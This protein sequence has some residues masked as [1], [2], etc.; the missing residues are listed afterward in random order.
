MKIKKLFPA[1]S[2]IALAASALALSVFSASDLFAVSQSGIQLTSGVWPVMVRMDY[3]PILQISIK[4]AHGA[5]LTE[6]KLDFTKTTHVSDIAEVEVFVGG[7]LKGAG[8]LFGKAKPTKNNPIVTVKGSKPTPIADGKPIWIS[9]KMRTGADI[10]GTVNCTG[11]QIVLDGR[12]FSIN[13]VPA[14]QRVGYAVA[15]SGDLGSK[16]YRIPAVTTTKKGTLVATFDIRYG[17]AGDLPAN[18][19][20]GV[21]TSVDGGKTWTPVKSVLSSKDMKVKKGVGDP[22]ILYDPKTNTVWIAALWAPQSG[23]PIWTS[24]SG[25]TATDNC[26]Q[27]LLINSK[28]EG[29]TWSKPKN[30]TADIKRL[31]DS[32][33]ARWGLIFQGPGAGICTKDGTLIFPGQV[34]MR[35]AGN[36]K[37]ESEGASQGVLIYSKDNGKTWSSTKSSPFGGSESTCL[38]KKNGS[39]ALN[40]RTNKGWG[41]TGSILKKIDST[42]DWIVDENLKSG[43]KGV[44][45]QPGGCQASLLSVGSDWFFSNPKSGSRDH[46]TIRHSKNEGDS[47][48]EGLL[49]DERGCAGYSSLVP[50]DGGKRIGVLYEGTPNSEVISFLSIPIDEVKKAK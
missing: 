32:D 10:T 11:S 19:D 1:S 30:I 25:S 5:K 16:N 48:N 13:S 37:T 2:K 9:V 44:L 26:G 31:G 12:P 20:I 14:S 21:C 49:Y 17:S 47:W 34:W 28:N 29:K 4:D 8:T 39:I 33:T 36:N 42:T 38:E 43:A 22:G 46:M 15:K 7:D 3:N 45:K 50:V 41:R 23:H 35:N 6:L 40:T 27:V 24:V 18:I